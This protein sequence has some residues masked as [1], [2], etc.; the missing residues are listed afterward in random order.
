VAALAGAAVMVVGM[1]LG[2]PRKWMMPAGAIVCFVLREY[3]VW[4]HL[5]LPKASG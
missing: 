3:A 5:N 1:R 2:L 4:R